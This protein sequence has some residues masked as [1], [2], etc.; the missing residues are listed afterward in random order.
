MWPMTEFEPQTTGVVSI[1]H[2]L[3]TSTILSLISV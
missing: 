2:S 1:N 3:K